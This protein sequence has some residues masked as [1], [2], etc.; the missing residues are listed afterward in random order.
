MVM[1]LNCSKFGD[2]AG[3]CRTYVHIVVSEVSRIA[4]IVAE[5][6]GGVGLF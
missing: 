1:K 5:H 6:T 3:K 4:I 2:V